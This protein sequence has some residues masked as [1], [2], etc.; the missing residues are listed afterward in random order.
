MQLDGF[1][2]STGKHG[3]EPVPEFCQYLMQM[4]AIEKWNHYSFVT[5]VLSFT[6]L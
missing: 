2:Q 3:E 4:F 1:Q 5:S 6:F